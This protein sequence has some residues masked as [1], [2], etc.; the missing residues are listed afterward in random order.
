[1]SVK[2]GSAA[3]ESHS[4]CFSEDAFKKL[5]GEN[6]ELMIIKDAVHTDLYDQMNVIPFD[7][8]AAVIISIDKGGKNRYNKGQVRFGVYYLGGFIL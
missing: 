6:K 7:K 4:C 1:M 3:L 8:M 5:K 2:S